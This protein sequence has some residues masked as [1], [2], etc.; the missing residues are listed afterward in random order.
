MKQSD[1]QAGKAI[2]NHDELAFLMMLKNKWKEEGLNYTEVS[3]FLK[4]YFSLT[5]D[6][7]WEE[8]HLYGW[9]AREIN[10]VEKEELDQKRQGYL[11]LKSNV[12]FPGWAEM[13]YEPVLYKISRA[14]LKDKNFE[15]TEE[16]LRR[17]AYRCGE[18]YDEMKT[19]EAR[20][21][22]AK[23]DAFWHSVRDEILETASLNAFY[24]FWERS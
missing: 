24:Q 17:L 3:D 19:R 13:W 8:L 6:I 4:D 1:S 20:G 2:R 11:F 16:D 5:E 15:P 10:Q 21:E 18:N 7:S 14:E 12:P 9:A 23:E 22:Y